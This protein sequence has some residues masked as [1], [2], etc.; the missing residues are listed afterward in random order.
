LTLFSPPPIFPKSPKTKKSPKKIFFTCFFEFQIFLVTRLSLCQDLSL[1]NPLFDSPDT[2]HVGFTRGYLSGNPSTNSCLD[3][4]SASRLPFFS[5]AFLLSITPLKVLPD[6]LRKHEKSAY[7]ILGFLTILFL[8]LHL[9][10]S[11]LNSFPSPLLSFHF[12]ES[13]F[14]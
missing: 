8:D 12:L 4:P 1:N 6:Y 11:I 7:E 5:A 13:P 14:P 9:S 3:G 10:F 2:I